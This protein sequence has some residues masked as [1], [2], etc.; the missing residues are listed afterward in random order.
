MIT[1]PYC[2]DYTLGRLDGG[3]M[4]LGCGF[5]LV[6]GDIPQ[7]NKKTETKK[8]QKTF[9]SVKNPLKRIAVC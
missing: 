4:C 6:S 8:K 7:Q 5:I 2:G 1:C 9:L 3:A